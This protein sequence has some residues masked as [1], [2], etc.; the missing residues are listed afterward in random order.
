MDEE[1]EWLVEE[2]K[3]QEAARIR[4][5]YSSLAAIRSS[6]VRIREALLTDEERAVDERV[7]A[8]VTEATEITAAPAPVVEEPAVAEGHGTHDAHDAH[9]ARGAVAEAV[10]GEPRQAPA[11]SVPSAPGAAGSDLGLT[12]RQVGLLVALLEGGELPATG[13]ASFLSLEVDA[14]NECFLDV[15]GDTVVEFVGEEPRLVEDYE[16]DVREALGL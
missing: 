14:I 13:A 7:E 8:G 9:A 16:D 11:P 1:I 10:T 12:D 6:Q 2:R 4:I 3:R 15:V 5:D